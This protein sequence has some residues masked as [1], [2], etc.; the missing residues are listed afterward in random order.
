MQRCCRGGEWLTLS[1]SWLSQ[2]WILHLLQAFKFRLPRVTIWLLRPSLSLEGICIQR[3][4]T[5]LV[6]IYFI[7]FCF[8]PWSPWFPFWCLQSH[9]KFGICWLS[10]FH[11]FWFIENVLE[12]LQRIVFL[13]LSL[14]LL[15]GRI[16]V[17]H[18][19]CLG[20]FLHFLFC[21]CIW[22]KSQGTKWA[23]LKSRSNL[24]AHFGI[25]L[26]LKISLRFLETIFY[27][28]QM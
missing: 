7:R 24:L 12:D 4:P 16:V 14:K 5:L 10:L 26:W 8:P 17:W 28:G 20:W 11:L 1:P 13:A 27:N 23:T 22:W 2:V 3:S 18:Y 15:K 19:F 6:H 9:G 25:F 21:W